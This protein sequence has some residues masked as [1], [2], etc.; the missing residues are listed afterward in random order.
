MLIV[1]VV[2]AHVTIY[3]ASSCGSAILS[4]FCKGCF[5][6]SVSLHKVD[7]EILNGLSRLIVLFVMC[8]GNLM[9]TAIVICHCSV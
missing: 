4:L 8:E 6:L 3:L 5:E 1:R 9:L 7:G 2:V